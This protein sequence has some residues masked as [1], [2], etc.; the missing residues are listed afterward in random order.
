MICLALAPLRGTRRIACAHVLAIVATLTVG[1]AAPL[2]RAQSMPPTRTEPQRSLSG[3]VILQGG[4]QPVTMQ[5]VRVLR[6]YSLSSVRSNPQV[7]VGTGRV[8]FTPI[9][10]NPHAL[11]NLAERLRAI[12]QQVQVQEN[13]ADVNEI[14]QG[15]ILHQVLSYQVQP[16]TCSNPSAQDQ[17]ARAGVGCFTKASAAQREAAFNMPKNAHF[18]ADPV[19]RRTAIMAAQNQSAAIQADASKH[20]ADLRAQFANPSQRAAISAKIGA[21]ETAR[22][23]GLSDDELEGEII[24][25]STERIEETAFVPGSQTSHYALPPT[26]LNIA[27][28]ADEIATGQH[29]ADGSLSPQ[30]P[31]VSRYPNL[32]RVEPSSKY[33]PTSGAPPSGGESVTDL[34]LGTY[35]FLTGFTL[36]HDYEWSLTVSTT[37]NWCIIGC[38]STYSVTLYA[39]FNYGFGLRFPVQAE[40]KYHNAVHPDNSATASLNAVFTPLEATMQQFVSTNIDP[41]QIFNAQELVAQVG[42]DAGFSYNLPVV[43]SNNMGISIGVDFTQFLPAPY[44]GGKFTPPAPGT[45][46]I[47]SPFI[48]DQ[49]DLLGG[50]LNFGAIG[51]EVFPAIDINLHSDKLQFTVDDEISRHSTIVNSGQS[52]NVGTSASGT[53]DSHF[54]FGNPVYNLGF[55]LTPGIDAR[56]FIDLAVWGQTWD[57]PIWLPQLAVTIPSGGIDFACHAGTTC[58]LDFQ[59]EYQAGMTSGLLAQLAAEGCTRAANTMN[60][61]TLQG[62]QTCQTAVKSNSILG[63]QSCNP[64]MVVSE[65]NAADRTLTGGGCQRD[66]AIGHYLCANQ[67][68]MLNLCKTMLKNGAV[69]SCDLLVPIQTDQILTRG[70]CSVDPGKRGN[71]SCPNSMLGLCQLYVKNQVIYSCQ[72]K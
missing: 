20:I 1:L 52:V 40:L 48:L 6:Q 39:G 8:D 55:T 21:A 13:S 34:N 61:T 70:G 46:G 67:N 4:N 27:P 50:L 28:S 3:S 2:A 42:A 16:G 14:E 18:V 59:P 43:G 56:L 63:V 11:V 45:H 9:F 24:N 37:I 12:P 7:V 53:H 58:V 54:S 10:S 17:L 19:K 71:Y 32:F 65:E 41:T 23:S 68:G 44:T 60:C 69:L 72:K 29:L 22:L 5:R 15:L 47:D 66:G 62:L 36:G 35:Y 31:A 51:G 57:F 64:G 33:Q 26:K 38:S 25:S 30:S 49:I